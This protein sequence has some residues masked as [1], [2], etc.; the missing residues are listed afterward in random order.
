MVV[1]LDGKKVAKEIF[2]ETQTRLE[3]LKK[4]KIIPCLAIILVGNNPES[5]IFVKQKLKKAKELGIKVKIFK[6]PQKT[7]YEKVAK[8]LEELNSSSEVGGILIQLPLPPHI[9]QERILEKIAP[10]KEVDGL[11]QHS[12]FP[13]ACASGIIRMLKFYKIELKGKKVLIL[14]Q[15]RVVGKPLYSLIKQ[16]GAQVSFV[17]LDEVK[18]LKSADILISAIPIKDVIKPEMIKKGAVV[19]DVAKNVNPKVAEV[20]GYLTPQRGGVGPVTVATLLENTVKAAS[21]FRK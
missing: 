11:T 8:L 21:L 17:E 14:G 5:I 4:R 1:I 9:S 7:S 16:K 10:N 18:K 15:G 6:L 12:P 19:V 20:A 13:P 2:R 3:Q